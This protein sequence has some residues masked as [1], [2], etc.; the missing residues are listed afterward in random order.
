MSH[1]SHHN[2]LTG[3]KEIENRA[4]FERIVSIR[5]EKFDSWKDKG[6]EVIEQAEDAYLIGKKKEA[7]DL[8]VQ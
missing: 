6:Y 7:V 8:K 4:A 5:K 3:T 1:A 2:I